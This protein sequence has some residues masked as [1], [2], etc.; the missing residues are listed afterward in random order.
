MPS[1]GGE[2][3]ITDSTHTRVSDPFNSNVGLTDRLSYTING[4]V[5]AR[6]TVVEPRTLQI[7][8]PFNHQG[9]VILAPEQG[10]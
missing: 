7:D 1:V 2:V 8:D 3:G 4:V 6:P 5:T 10:A 9:S